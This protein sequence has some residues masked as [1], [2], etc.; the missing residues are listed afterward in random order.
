MSTLIRPSLHHLSV[1]LL[2]RA[3]PKVFNSE[4]LPALHSCMSSLPPDLKFEDPSAFSVKS[5][6]EL[7]RALGVFQLCSF[8]VL[9]NN[10]GKL[11]SAA[12]SILGKQGFSLI[13][14]P[15][16]YAQ[17]VAGESEGEIAVA[18]E[19]MRSLGLRTML[20]VPIEEDLGESTGE[21]RYDEN[22]EAM[23]QCVYLS[24]SKAC[25]YPK[26]QLKITALLS[27]EL[28]VKITSNLP[29]YPFDLAELVKAMDGEPVRFPGLTEEEN[30]HFHCG[31]RRLNK[32]GEASFSKVRVLVDAEYTYMNPALSL[33][34]M[35]MMKKFNQK[36]P[37]VWNT[38]QCYLKESRSLLLDAISQS[39]KHSFCLGVKLVRGAY[40]DKERKLAKGE[41]RPDPIH[42]SWE[43]TNARSNLFS[44][45]NF[46]HCMKNEVR[47]FS[48]AALSY[49]WHTT[50]DCLC[51]MHSHLLEI[52]QLD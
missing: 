21:H 25:A 6:R 43:D 49:M 8:P 35:A 9:V 5:F 27:P 28:C 18:M 17:F 48:G 19:K 41:G 47:S 26:M 4:H 33:V 45:M 36:E 38:F 7:M 31:L 30:A 14:R 50:G 37:W 2:R 12:R 10:C 32:V 15:S 3:A 24:H 39:V 22:L 11:L 51:Q 13:M 46:G 1:P 34:T 16:I 52:V 29:E 42:Q 44:H 23:L 20:A 40:M